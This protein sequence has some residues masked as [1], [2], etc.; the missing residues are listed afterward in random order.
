MP[1]RCGHVLYATFVFE[2]NKLLIQGSI[3][4]NLI[5]QEASDRN[6]YFRNDSL[7]SIGCTHANAFVTCITKEI[8]HML[9]EAHARLMISYE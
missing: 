4:L 3:C 9:L 2:I 1:I 5:F 6:Q 7:S 8:G